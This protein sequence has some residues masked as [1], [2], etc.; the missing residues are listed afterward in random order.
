[1]ILYKLSNNQPAQYRQQLRSEIIKYPLFQ[2]ENLA[3]P[4]V[5]SQ[6]VSDLWCT[7]ICASEIMGAIFV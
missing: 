1:M 4:D 3:S 2:Y 7:Y 5:M 6:K